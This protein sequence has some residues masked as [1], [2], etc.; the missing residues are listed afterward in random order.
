MLSLSVHI[1]IGRIRLGSTLNMKQSNWPHQTWSTLNMKQSFAVGEFVP[2]RIQSFMNHISSIRV[3]KAIKLQDYKNMPRARDLASNLATRREALKEMLKSDQSELKFSTNL[4]R[5]RRKLT[6]EN[7]L[8][9]C[10]SLKLSRFLQVQDQ[11]GLC[12]RLKN[13]TRNTVAAGE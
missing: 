13:C 8:R 10:W 12:L 4:F 7:S 2:F 3:H 1:Q 9:R 6:E 11:Q 5:S